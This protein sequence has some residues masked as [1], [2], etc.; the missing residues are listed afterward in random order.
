MNL[1]AYAR[2]LHRKINSAHKK[3]KNPFIDASAACN[4]FYKPIYTTLVWV[5]P[6]DEEINEFNRKQVQ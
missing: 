1:V 5:E 3:A 4:P 2:L 6:D